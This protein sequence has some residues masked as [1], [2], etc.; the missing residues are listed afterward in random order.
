MLVPVSWLKDYVDIDNI[1]IEELEEKLILSGSNTEG[2]QKVI[3]DAKK[4]VIGKIVE[5][6]KHPNA[7]KLVIPMV[8]IG[9]EVIQI[10]TGAEN[11]NV[12]D[13]VPVALV[14]SRLPGGIKIKRGKLRGEVSNGM[15]CSAEELGFGDSV[16]PKDMKDGILILNGEYT[17]GEGIEEALGLNDHVIEFEITPNRPDCLSMLGMARETSATFDLATKYPEINIK[18]EV[19][20]INDYISAEVEDKD[21]CRR[22]VGRVVKDIKIEPSP[23]WLQLRLMKAGVRPISN[24]VDITNFVMLEYGQPLHA[25]DLNTLT[26]GKIIARR[27]KKDEVTT[28][29]DGAERKLDE[30]VLVIADAKDTIGIAG[31]MGGE[32]TEIS[33]NT[34]TIFIEAAHFNKKNIRTSSRKI[35]LRTEASARFEKGIDPNVA[36]AAADRACQLIEE[37]GAGKVVKGKIDIY[38]D[39]LEGWSIEV[40]P[41]RINS[42]L[43]TKLS[44]EEISDILRRLELSVEKKEEKLLVGIPTYRQDLLKE[45]DIV[46]EVARIYGYNVIEATLP[47]GATWGAKTNAQVIEDYTK[48]AL[49]SLGLNEITTYSFVSPKSLDLINTPED[50]FLRRNIKLLNPLGEEYS[51]MRTTLVPNMLDVLARNYKRNVS[52]ALAFELGNTFIPREIPVTSLPIEKKVLTLGMYGEDIDFFSIK[53][54]VWELLNKLGIEKCVMEPEKNHSLFH[55]GRCGNIVYGNH[56][57]GTIGEVHPDILENYGFSNRVYVADID[58]N[59]LLQITRIDTI[60]KPLPKY[61]STSRDMALIV[62]EEIYSK[63]IEDII[64]NNGGDILETCTLFDVYRGK[65]ISE[66]NKSMAYSLTFRAKDR[67]LTDEE[68]NK[69][70]D[71]MLEELS[72]KLSAELR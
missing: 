45:I 64:N 71:K 57:L 68:V 55:P 31:I 53:A 17:L 9:E 18:E 16:I 69:V 70:F 65:Q 56:I 48:G 58:F 25:Y 15:L 67:T 10:V 34:K 39:K 5:I 72:Q 44:S 3:E 63:E 36:E 43:G 47:K 41:E 12:G 21:L 22:F 38:D 37:L 1:P 46:E 13:Y 30:E 52:E 24:I 8:D 26:G 49:N 33:D 29:L 51:I 35:G 54:I 42:L 19:E 14:G 7:D 4:I 27:A 61:P 20:D 59:I 28:T 62:K 23:T 2:V 66:G 6:K 60:Y 32:D 50:S 40:R 11:I